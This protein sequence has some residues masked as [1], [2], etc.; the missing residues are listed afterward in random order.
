MANDPKLFKKPF[1]SGADAYKKTDV[2]TANRET[3]L[4]M[5]YAGAIRFLKKAIEAHEKNEVAEKLTAIQRT[6]DI[7]N[8][9]RATLNF[10]V[11]G[12]IA[13][14]LSSLYD[15]VLDR[16][17][18]A[19][20]EKKVEHLQEALSILNTLNTAWEEAVATVRRERASAA[21]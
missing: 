3:I 21:K 5:M 6:Q 12:E 2:M 15:F 18:Q 4:L 20:I 10:E 19:T 14:S 7:I 11:G 8:E 13:T 1:K 17:I 9:L 16:L